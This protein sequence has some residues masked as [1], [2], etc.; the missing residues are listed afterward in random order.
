MSETDAY[1]LFVKDRVLLLTSQIYRPTAPACWVYLTA[2]QVEML[3]NMT[4]YLN[5]PNTYVEEYAGHRYLTPDAEQFD[6]IQAIVADLEEKLMG[7]L[8]VVWG[9]KETLGDTKSWT[10]DA[11]TPYTLSSDAVP[12]GEVWVV[13]SVRAMHNNATP[14][15]MWMYGVNTGNAPLIDGSQLA[16]ANVPIANAQPIVLEYQGKI[17]VVIY[18]LPTSKILYLHIQGYKM[19]VPV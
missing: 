8:N 2:Q 16:A 10:S 1:Y 7:N 17:D 6:G 18:G 5:R 15:A 19:E 12:E 13:N 9:Y 11:T 3:R 4:Q 14:L